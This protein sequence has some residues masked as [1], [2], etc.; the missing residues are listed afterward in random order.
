MAKKEAPEAA[1]SAPL[2]APIPSPGSLQDADQQRHTLTLQYLCLIVFITAIPPLV[3]DLVGGFYIAASILVVQ[4]ICVALAYFWAKRGWNKWSTRVLAY[5][6][7]FSACG[8]IAVSEQGL[9]NSALLMFP[10]SL[11]LGALLIE[12]RAYIVFVA[13][14]AGSLA[15]IT[16]LESK[17]I[18]KGGLPPFG[19]FL[20][21]I[22]ILLITA[23]VAALIS[24]NLKASLTL[25]NQ[26]GRALQS[27]VTATS[28]DRVDFFE[29]LALELSKVLGVKYVL[30]AERLPGLPERVRTVAFVAD[31]RVIENVEYGL[32]GTPCES[33]LDCG[34]CYFDSGLQNRFPDDKA[35][36]KLRVTSYMGSPLRNA[37]GV[38]IGLIAVMDEKPIESLA[39]AN[40]LV[41]IFAT[42]AASELERKQVERALRT[43]EQRYR[44]TL[45]NLGEGIV[46]MDAEGR[47]LMVNPAAERIFGA[48]SGSLE[49]RRL[50]E[51]IAPSGAPGTLPN[52]GAAWPGKSGSFELSIVGLDGVRRQ[53][54]LTGTPQR[55]A[56]DGEESPATGS[57][58]VIRDVTNSRR[59]EDRVRL[60]ATALGGASDCISISDADYR[61]LY[62]NPSFLR[63]YGYEEHE[64]VGQSI[65]IVCSPRNP[66]P[67]E[68]SM[69]SGDWTGELWNVTR[70][71]RE[72]L[73]SL[74]TSVIR[75]EQ[76][77]DIASVG[78]AR[79]IT[80]QRAL[81]DHYLQS[82]KL[83]GIGRLAGGVAHD[84]NNL[85]TVING[86]SSM[87]LNSMSEEDPKRSRITQIH[88]AGKRAAELTQQL[89]TFSRKQFSQPVAMNLNEVVSES[90]TLFSRLLGEDIQL[91]TSLEVNEA[92]IMA[93]TGQI[94]QILMNLA[95]NARDAMPGGGTL[96]IS[97][98]PAEV[99]TEN[100]NHPA[101]LATGRY[102]V[103]A[104]SDTGI[105]MTPETMAHIF[106]PFFSTKG[107]EGTG[108][109]LST[110]YG[111]V[112]QN[113]GAI[114]V[115]S[116][117]E[118]GTTFEIW[119]PRI[120]SPGREL[121]AKPGEAGLNGEGTVLVVE[122]HHDV[123]DMVTTALRSY[124]YQILDA[125]TAE[126]ALQLATG[127]KGR[128]D[129][130]LT[131]VVLPA[132]NGRDLSERFILLHPESRVLF[133]SGYTS[134]IIARRGVEEE[135]IAFLPKPYSVEVLGA[136]VAELMNQNRS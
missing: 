5:S 104:V 39:L 23:A 97:V 6:S 15:S 56:G 90:E 27:L 41:T 46:T 115:R 10:M 100:S 92:F 88:Y 35:L 105:G 119:L 61:I 109:G 112:Q 33:I 106:E 43:S 122:D 114:E 96:R 98:S 25:S 113:R 75:D 107:P 111:I 81:Q 62:V 12:G 4:E 36:S 71:G 45:R 80:A 134:D 77:R 128:I 50:T 59:M 131:D 85:L 95:V 124:G 99:L 65:G 136:K 63:T 7:V 47:F 133:T 32:R 54:L 29:T 79:D 38:P 82:Q 91:I 70:D 55:E 93:D 78:V 68:A 58:G 108:L 31:Q 89:L 13:V 103:L 127:Y 20:D 16:V 101:G 1:L 52:A 34:Q 76:G 24:R 26:Y 64:L 57:V 84:F 37:S 117:P 19:F 48:P 51:F 30:I 74:S 118:K 8:F 66:F 60:L 17:G 87:L 126:E 110:V 73:I 11:V 83:E 18:V 72:F 130:L 67:C 44:T 135:R 129:L 3:N 86:Y 94:H 53:V 132:M 120:E 69:L 102:L 22:A 2:W 49:G 21:S 121:T 14:M 123:R 28:G 9:H 42:R 125:G 116:E 40:S